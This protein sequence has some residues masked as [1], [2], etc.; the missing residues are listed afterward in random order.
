MQYLPNFE[1]VCRESGVVSEVTGLLMTGIKSCA[2]KLSHVMS[3]NNIDL[4]TV[5][6]PRDLN[7]F[8]HSLSKL[9]TCYCWIFKEGLWS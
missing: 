7:L 9:I 1:K 3:K 4:G 8:V 2:V 6:V 5:W